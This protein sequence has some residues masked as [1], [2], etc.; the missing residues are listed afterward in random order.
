[1]A[2]KQEAIDVRYLKGLTYRDAEEREIEEQGVKKIKKF[3]REAA[4]RPEHVL[5]WRDAG[6]EI[7]IVSADGRKHKVAKSGKAAE[8][9]TVKSSLDGNVTQ[10]VD[11]ISKMNDIAAIKAYI[12]GDERKGVTDAA[13][14]AIAGL[15]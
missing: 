3:P 11:A 13:E 8:A 12:K 1:M 15:K 5:S 2:E 6:K 7:V 9:P 14:A 4:L 10:A